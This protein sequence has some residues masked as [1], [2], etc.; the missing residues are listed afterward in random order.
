MVHC[1]THPMAFHIQYQHF[2]KQSLIFLL[3]HQF[4]NFAMF[5]LLHQIHGKSYQQCSAVAANGLR[6]SYCVGKESPGDGCP[7]YSVNVT[8]TACECAGDRG[9]YWICHFSWPVG[10]AMATPLNKP[11]LSKFATSVC[12]FCCS[13]DLSSRRTNQVSHCRHNLVTP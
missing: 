12:T 11:L 10:M 4:R 8:G 1:Y 13:S 5:L 2:L 3:L 9:A 6:L 7:P